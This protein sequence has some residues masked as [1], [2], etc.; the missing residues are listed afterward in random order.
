MR[1]L[2][3]HA[4]SSHD[5][6]YAYA[7]GR[8]RALE[9]TLLGKQRLERIA[10]AGDV[11]EVLRQLS[12]TA[13]APHLDEI[14]EDGYQA[15]LKNEERRLLDLVDSLSLDREVSD[16]LRLG[17]DFHNLKVALR[18]GVSGRDLEDLYM[19]IGRFDGDEIRGPVRDEEPDGLPEMF[20]DAA[21]QA[22]A[23]YGASRDPGDADIIVD[24][25]M[26]ARF[27]QVAGGYGGPF[28]KSIVRTWIDLANI[29]T[30]MRARYLG[31]E[32]RALPGLLIEGGF[33]KKTDFSDIFQF[34]L[35]EIL[36][37]FE[38]SP[39]RRV[40]ELGGAAAEK[41]GSFIPLEREMDNAV[42]SLLR[43]TRYFT[44][45]LEVVVAYALIKQIEIKV[46]RLVLAGKDGGTAP[47]LIKERIPDGE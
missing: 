17:H 8:V 6:R 24:K 43:I 28:L 5:Q 40:V 44:F 9:M 18:E 22:L 11:D 25:A 30:L 12:D 34:T 31:L 1:Y 19:D 33:V 39:Y 36:G 3:A 10:E 47:D 35:D 29:R 37:R 42:I 26:F 32:A 2:P 45:G 7:S 4:V 20:K 46:L 16:I 41:D 23:A 14:E 27:L 15:F 21:K 13:Y 38:F